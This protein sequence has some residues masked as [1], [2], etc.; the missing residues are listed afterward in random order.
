MLWRGGKGSGT[1]VWANDGGDDGSWD[2][3][4]ANSE[5][6]EDKETPGSVECVGFQASESA[7]ACGLS[8]LVILNRRMGHGFRTL[9]HC[10]DNRTDN[11]QLPVMTFEGT[12]QQKHKHSSN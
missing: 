6:G 10:H 1:Y 5:T 2:N 7:G 12:E 3:D 4:A 11:H 9:T 8:E